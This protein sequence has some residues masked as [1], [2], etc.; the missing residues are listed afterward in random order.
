MPA[1]IQRRVASG[2]RGSR[3]SALVGVPSMARPPRNC[4][5]GSNLYS[6]PMEPKYEL[7]QS[8][9]SVV[10]GCAGLAYSTVNPFNDD[11]CVKPRSAPMLHCSLSMCHQLAS[12]VAGVSKTALAFVS[13]KTGA[14]TGR[15]KNADTFAGTPNVA[16]PVSV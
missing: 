1:V 10:V 2:T 11:H 8:N 7:L 15:V 12:A 14:L 3:V 5:A 4:H 6:A 9:V 13:W 16:L